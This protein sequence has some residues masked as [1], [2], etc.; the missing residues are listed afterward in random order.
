MGFKGIASLMGW[1]VFTSMC[2][3][4][5]LLAKSPS[6]TCATDL[7]PSL[8]RILKDSPQAKVIPKKGERFWFEDSVD[9]LR[10]NPKAKI[11]GLQVALWDRM[12]REEPSEAAALVKSMGFELAGFQKILEENREA[13]L[14]RKEKWREAWS[15]VLI[16]AVFLGVNGYYDYTTP[17]PIRMQMTVQELKDRRLD[18]EAKNEDFTKFLTHLQR[19][20]FPPQ[21]IK[22]GNPEIVGT[23]ISSEGQI[24]EGEYLLVYAFP[25]ATTFDRIRINVKVSGPNSIRSDFEFRT[26]WKAGVKMDLTISPTPRAPFSNRKPEVP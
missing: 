24:T 7:L 3:S 23:L 20:M 4:S 5:C 19:Y 12:F 2:S 15:G 18:P 8:Y 25:Q 10:R 13:P 21:E 9:R 17:S 16:A 11:L 1:L 22:I 26:F 6:E 14:T